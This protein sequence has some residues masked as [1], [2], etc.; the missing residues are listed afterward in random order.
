MP[1]F[2]VRTENWHFRGA[3]P[4]EKKS[5]QTGK[6]DRINTRR[7]GF[8]DVLTPL[9]FHQQ[10][11]TIFRPKGGGSG[12]PLLLLRFGHVRSRSKDLLPADSKHKKCGALLFAKQDFRAPTSGT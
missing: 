7:Q 11:T 5:E 2:S 6:D 8:V 9:G 1:N 12:S 10:K 3:P 4:A